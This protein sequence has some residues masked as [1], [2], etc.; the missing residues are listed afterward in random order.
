MGGLSYVYRF[1]P[2]LLDHPPGDGLRDTE[3]CTDIGERNSRSG[4][5]GIWCLAHRFTVSARTCSTFFTTIC[6][7]IGSKSFNLS[8]A[9]S[10]FVKVLLMNS[11]EK[12]FRRSNLIVTCLSF[13][14]IVSP[15]AL[16]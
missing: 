4:K 15:S 13:L 2:Y 10:R 1:H 9:S 5:G 8:K 12:S 6:K 14:G 16:T 11:L 7:S 3:T